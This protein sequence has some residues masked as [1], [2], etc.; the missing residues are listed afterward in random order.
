MRPKIIVYDDSYKSQLEELLIGF[1]KEIYGVGTADVETF[2]ASHHYIYLAVVGEEVVGFASF[3]HNY[4]F[5]MRS[6]TMGMNYLYVKPA[7]RNGRASYLLTMQVGAVCDHMNMDLEV[8]L[9]S[10][11]STRIVKRMDGGEFLYTV[12]TYPVEEVRN[13]YSDLKN[14][15]KIE[16]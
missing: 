13:T 15:I 6:P 12:Y 4:Y 2:V 9:A 1:S 7:Y 3:T 14:Y 8:Y 16:E 5:G 11:D 10:E